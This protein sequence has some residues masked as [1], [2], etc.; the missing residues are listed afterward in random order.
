[1]REI[2]SQYGVLESAKLDAVKGDLDDIWYKL[3][4]DPATRQYAAT[5]GVD[6][7][8]VD[9]LD[10]NPFRAEPPPAN[11]AGVVEAVLIGVAVSIASDAIKAGLRQV[12]EK[13]VRP[14]IENRHG[15]VEDE[16]DHS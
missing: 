3:K 6:L 5:L 7:S 15:P 8:G 2:G 12:W 10:E 13:L 1:V 9:E 4:S 16:P 14:N 11:R